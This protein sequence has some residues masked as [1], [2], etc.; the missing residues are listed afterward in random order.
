M[1]YLSINKNKHNE[2]RWHKI[3][4]NNKILLNKDGVYTWCIDKNPITVEKY[5]IKSFFKKLQIATINR[6]IFI[7]D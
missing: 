4:K 3:F 5:S 1:L 2:Q 6:I 7:I